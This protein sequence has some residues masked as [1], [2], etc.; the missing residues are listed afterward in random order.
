MR[1]LSYFIDLL[2]LQWL[3]NFDWLLLLITC[4]FNNNMLFHFVK[5]YLKLFLVNHDHTKILARSHFKCVSIL[6]SMSLCIK[7]LTLGSPSGINVLRSSTDEPFSTSS[8]PYLTSRG[9]C[10]NSA[11]L[12]L[13][14][15]PHTNSGW[16]LTELRSLSKSS[17]LPILSMFIQ[18][19]LHCLWW[20]AI[21]A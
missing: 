10:R 7:Y 4:V 19:I 3:F 15:G 6:L 16:S 17:T 20:N 21:V 12:I 2:I 1:M 8:S 14:S 18:S 11:I 5:N 9:P 13:Q